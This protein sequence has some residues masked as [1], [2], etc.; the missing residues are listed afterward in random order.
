MGLEGKLKMLLVI[1]ISLSMFIIY[2]NDP[3]IINT[4]FNITCNL[5]FY[6]TI[7]KD[8]YPYNMHLITEKLLI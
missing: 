8:Y 2:K 7:L 4:R 6:K 5:Y 1:N 3:N